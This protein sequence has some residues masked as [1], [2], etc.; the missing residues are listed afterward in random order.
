MAAAVLG[1]GSSDIVV[2]HVQRPGPPDTVF[3]EPPHDLGHRPVS[4]WRGRT[5]ERLGDDGQ[6]DRHRADRSGDSIVT[7]LMIFSHVCA[8]DAGIPARRGLPGRDG[9]PGRIRTA[10]ANG[11]GDVVVDGWSS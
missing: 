5:P 4:G 2:R 7:T 3:Y 6:G 11:Y 8:H 10:A 1:H 9:E